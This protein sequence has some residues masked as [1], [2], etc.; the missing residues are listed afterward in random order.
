MSDPNMC[1]YVILASIL[2]L[3]LTIHDRGSVMQTCVKLTCPIWYNLG[4]ILHDKWNSC[5]FCRCDN[6]PASPVKHESCIPYDVHCILA[7]LPIV[8]SYHGSKRVVHKPPAEHCERS[9]DLIGHVS[10]GH[11]WYRYI[12]C[13]SS[14][15]TYRNICCH[16]TKRIRHPEHNETNDCICWHRI[17]MNV[18]F[19]L[20]ISLPCLLTD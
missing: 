5:E 6:R 9:R 19:P 16:L 20:F 14:H 1:Q 11:K 7:Y 13:C 12:R 15:P 17:Y 2:F 3:F 10:I 18:T 8:V 4:P